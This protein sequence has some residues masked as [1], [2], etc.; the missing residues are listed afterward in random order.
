M[1]TSMKK[2]LA[3][4]LSAILV[5]SLSSTTLLASAENGDYTGGEVNPLACTHTPGAAV[6]ENEV[7]ATCVKDGSYD[8]V[9]YCT[10]CNTELS[11]THK[12]INATG[13]HTP[14]AAV[15]ENEV[16]AT[17]GKDGSYDE[18]VYCTVCNTE[19][20]RTPKTINATGIHT[21]GET[22]QS[23]AENHWHICSECEQLVDT[24]AHTYSWV[25]VK[26]AT[27]TENGL[28]KE[29][30]SVCG[31]ESGNSEEIV[32]N[33]HI[34]GDINKDGS[35]NNKDLTRLF[36]YLSDWDVE[37]DEEALD[38]NDDGWVNN[39]DLTRLFQFL[40]DWDVDIH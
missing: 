37:V 11:R 30:C 31:Y 28:K 5:L 21:P 29:V 6:R 38:V 16:P 33:S 3:V 24:A 13:I 19:L 1:K 14:G 27:E 18:V 25:I 9:V 36:Q 12:T 39:K 26:K 32:Y 2:I 20:S 17:C 23:D 7:P 35:V 10:V 34:P 40:S 15:R 8:E 22:W 4:L